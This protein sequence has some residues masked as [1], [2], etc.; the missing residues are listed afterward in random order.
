M[1][2]FIS[3]IVVA[4]LSLVGTF[5]ASY[6]SNQKTTAII[7]YRIEQLEEKTNKHNNLIERTFE[8][9]QR[10]ALLEEKLKAANQRIEDLENS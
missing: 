8:L 1:L 3:T 9:E 10:E 5:A 6:M 4:V 7:A 2:T